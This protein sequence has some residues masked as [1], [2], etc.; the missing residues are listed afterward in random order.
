MSS[1]LGRNDYILLDELNHASII[2][3]ARLSF[4]KTLKFGHNNMVDLES[5]LKR[6]PTDCIKLIVVDGVFSMEGDLSDLPRIV[7]LAKKYKANIMVDDAHGIGVMGSH[8]KGT[9]AHYGLTSEVDLIMGTFSKSL[10]S[11]GGFIASD[12]DT[13]NFLKH[14]ARALIFSA[15]ISPANAASALAAIEIIENEPDRISRL[16][17]NTHYAHQLLSN[18]GF[19]LGES[20]TPIIPILIGDDHTTFKL[21]KNLLKDGVFVNPVVPPAVPNSSSLI[22]FT[23]MASFEACFICG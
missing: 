13:I 16:W 12:A 3:G 17:K 6:L 5:K 7:K 1:L 15:S 2:D 14:N 20:T 10:A 19:N 23:L 22:R 8:G 4:A 11:V 9:V 21:T 18:Y